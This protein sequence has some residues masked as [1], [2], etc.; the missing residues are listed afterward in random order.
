MV[1]TATSPE[2]SEGTAVHR[3]P[4]QTFSLFCEMGEIPQGVQLARG[5][6]SG[7]S[8]LGPWAQGPLQDRGPRGLAWAPRDPTQGRSG[9]RAGSERRAPPAAHTELAPVHGRAR[10]G[11]EFS[12]QMKKVALAM[13]TSLSDKDLDLLPTDMGHHGT[14]APSRG[15]PAGPA[16]RGGG[17]SGLGEWGAACELLPPWADRPGYG[18]GTDPAAPTPGQGLPLGPAPLRRRR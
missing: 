8:S 11:E 3:L 7:S 4:S 14:A 12:S 15:T 6:G 18:G 13:G 10:M 9:H 5:G 1:A 17:G 16:H 2:Q